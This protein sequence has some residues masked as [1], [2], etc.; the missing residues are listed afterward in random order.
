MKQALGHLAPV[1]ATLSVLALPGMLL[2]SGCAK[3]FSWQTIKNFFERIAPT[4]SLHY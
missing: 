1:M 3:D 4:L 2:I